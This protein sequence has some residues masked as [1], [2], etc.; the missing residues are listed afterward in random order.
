M[1]AVSLDDRDVSVKIGRLDL[2]VAQ[3]G[4]SVFTRAAAQ[5]EG[6]TTAD[7][8]RVEIDKTVFTIP[9]LKAEGSGLSGEDLARIFDTSQPGSLEDRLGRLTARSMTAPEVGIAPANAAA[10]AKNGHL[11]IR[12]VVLSDVA[13]G[14]IKALAA[15]GASMVGASNPD[16]T[17]TLDVGKLAAANLDVPLLVKVAKG[18]RTDDGAPLTPVYDS[19]SVSGIKYAE[20]SPATQS[21]EIGQIEATGFK[22]RPLLVPV[23]ELVKR[24]DDA[25]HEPAEDERKRTT[26]L[27]LDAL[28]SATLGHFGLHGIAY[29]GTDKGKPVGVKIATLSLDAG[30]VLRVS[31]FLI[32]GVSLNTADVDMSFARF[33]VEGLDQSGFADALKQSGSL[34]D[35][36]AGLMQ[37]QSMR[38]NFSKVALDTLHLQAPASGLDG[39]SADGSHYIFDVPAVALNMAVVADDKVSAGT[40]HV[41]VVYDI[42]PT[43][44]SAGLQALVKAGFG[45]IDLSND[46]AAGYDPT[47]QTFRLDR[48]AFAAKDLASLVLDGSVSNVSP[49]AFGSDKDTRLEAVQK[50]RLETLSIAF[51]NQSLVEKILPMLAAQANMTIPVFKKD[52]QLK[53]HQIVLETL[54]DGP[55]ATQIVKAGTAFIDQPKNFTLKLVAPKGLGLPEVAGAAEP[56]DVL[57]FMTVTATANQ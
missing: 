12:N 36:E 3:A 29:S 40:S 19:F 50:V 30:E 32:E 41:Q 22:A 18:S 11:V 28:R 44:P 31:K 4:F 2:P 43:A 6:T 15:D 25:E 14:K 45:H 13:A 53:L 21:F 55:A 26:S 56:K 47:K 24:L 16:L 39:N 49:E 7:N 35:F 57:N 8:I 27:M 9:H 23:R 52:L 37:G 48:L 33:T 20:T 34:P 51:V 54:G 42:A 17:A 5:A 1:D 10:A 38:P 46:T